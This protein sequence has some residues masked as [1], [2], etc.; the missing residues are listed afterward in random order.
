MNIKKFIKKVYL[1]LETRKQ[2]I[3]IKFLRHLSLYSYIEDVIRRGIHGEF[4][5][6][7]VGMVIPFLLQ[8]FLLIN[9]S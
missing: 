8:S 4:A 9:M 5:D 7:V 3:S 2:I 1:K 6:V